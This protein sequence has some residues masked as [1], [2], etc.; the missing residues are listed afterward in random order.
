MFFKFFL[1]SLFCCFCVFASSPHYPIENVESAQLPNVAADHL[2]IVPPHNTNVENQEGF[3]NTSMPYPVAESFQE[4]GLVNPDIQ[5]ENAERNTLPANETLAT[6]NTADLDDCEL[7][8]APSQLQVVPPV[9]TPTNITPNGTK[10]KRTTSLFRHEPITHNYCV[11]CGIGCCRKSSQS[12]SRSRG[13]AYASTAS[14]YPVHNGGG[15]TTLVYVGDDNRNT[16]TTCCNNV[17]C[18]NCVENGCC[19]CDCG[20][21]VSDVCQPIGQCFTDAFRA[22]G[23][24]VGECFGGFQECLNG[25]FSGCG[26]CVG[27]IGEMLS[28]CGQACVN[29]IGKLCCD[30]SCTECLSN[31]NCNDCVDSCSQCNCEGLDSCGSCECDCGDFAGGIGNAFNGALDFISGDD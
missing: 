25:C 23:N 10:A 21:A 2:S 7:Q 29:E 28:E 8:P 27:S 12:H 20:D 14:S 15:N 19:G 13:G 9:E 31:C 16:N 26:E 24:N 18:C 6:L 4:S 22:V 1:S 30:L 11:C 5:S 3:N 17:S